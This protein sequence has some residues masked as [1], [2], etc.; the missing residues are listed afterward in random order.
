VELQTAHSRPVRLVRQARTGDGH[1]PR[2]PLVPK[3]L[4]HEV[5]S[6]TRQEPQAVGGLDLLHWMDAE[7]RR[8]GWR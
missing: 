2:A 8:F 1:R 5:L 3:R 6:G 7:P 4:P